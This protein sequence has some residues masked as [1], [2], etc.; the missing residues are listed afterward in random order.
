MWN[1]QN[2]FTGWVDVPL[3]EKGVDEALK[4]GERI[5]H[6][7]FDAVFVSS[8][9]R[10]QITAYLALS[11]HDEGKVPVVTHKEAGKTG[12]WAK[13]YA[14]KSAANTIPVTEAWELNERM[15]GELQGLNKD[16]AR[17]EFGEEQVHIWR[18]S[19][20]VSPPGGESLKMTSE[21][22]LPYFKEKIIPLLENGKNIFVSAHGNS[23]RAI[24]MMLDKL[25]KEEVV[26]LEIPTGEPLC[27]T[28]S[29]NSW[30]KTEV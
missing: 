13:N 2:L 4:G 9:C 27:Y 15:Y 17:R 22:V 18:R 11:V 23:L 8:L 24:V 7:P 30:K 6:I 21:R 25:S 1:K 20:D 14:K 16:D 28:F 12:E 29:K 5:K 10:A 19:F 3:S 26:K